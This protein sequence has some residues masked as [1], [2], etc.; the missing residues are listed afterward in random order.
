MS[1]AEFDYGPGKA[2]GFFER[3]RIR[4]LLYQEHFPKFKEIC[5]ECSRAYLKARAEAESEEAVSLLLKCIE[6][7]ANSN[8]KEILKIMT[9]CCPDTINGLHDLPFQICNIIKFSKYPN[10]FIMQRDFE[11]N[12][13]EC[14]HLETQQDLRH[15]CPTDSPRDK[16]RSAQAQHQLDLFFKEKLIEISLSSFANRGQTQQNYSGTLKDCSKRVIQT[17]LKM[18]TRFSC[19]SEGNF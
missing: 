16:V 18:N 3:R 7:L 17:T 5:D 11:K 6:A 14:K 15:Y 12:A 10:S 8:C 4:R 9:A 13:N 19:T 1:V 2:F